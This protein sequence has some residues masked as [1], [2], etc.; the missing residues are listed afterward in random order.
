MTDNHIVHLSVDEGR[1]AVN[2]FVSENFEHISLHVP[3]KR[4]RIK[5]F[6]YYRALKRVLKDHTS[7][8]LIN[9]HIAYPG[10]VYAHK[11]DG[12]IQKKII[13]TEHWSAYHFHFFSEK[14]LNRIKRIFSHDFPLITVSKQL[15]QDI[16]RFAGRPIPERIIPN[17]VD[18]VIFKPDQAAKREKTLLLGAFW[19]KPKRPFLFLDAA[20]QFL[21]NNPEWQV[22]IFGHGPSAAAIEI[23]CEQNGQKF[24]GKLS[25]KQVAQEMQRS[26]GYIMPSDYETFSVGCAE[27]LCCGTPL[28]ISDRECTTGSFKWGKM[29]FQ[30]WSRNGP[31]R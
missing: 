7:Y 16:E 20:E 22:R 24:L 15:H 25:P 12:V 9:F 17:A 18:T 10:L 30:S 26:M 13:I 3:T 8:H 31:R 23:W 11:F 4:W 21:A 29:E 2:R 1:Y 14:P 28:L 5:E 6:L 19:K 27:A